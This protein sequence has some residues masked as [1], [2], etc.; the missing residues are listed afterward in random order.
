MKTTRFMKLGSTAAA[1]LLLAGL[2]S[3]TALSQGAPNVLSG[4]AIKAKPDPAGR[5]VG[6]YATAL[7]LV[8]YGK[9]NRS[10][11]ALIAAAEILGNVA[12]KPMTIEPQKITPTVVKLQTIKPGTFG[13]PKGV[14]N[15]ISLLSDAKKM[16]HNNPSVTSLANGVEK[17]L[18]EKTTR[19]AYGGPMISTEAESINPD[20]TQQWPVT[21]EGGEEA[22]FAVTPLAEEG[23]PQVEVNVFDGQRNAVASSYCGQQPCQVT[24]YPATTGPFYITVHNR[25]ASSVVY[26]FA[27]N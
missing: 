21:Y 1:L 5:Q 18:Q 23:I 25:G 10:P 15:P 9:R 6:M 14:L 8:S 16:S 24:F 26:D 22:T 2:F 13:N 7:S 19:G 12:T 3:G 11:V 27:T 20:E 4:A 17:E